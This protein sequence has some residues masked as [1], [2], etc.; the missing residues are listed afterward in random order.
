MVIEEL[1]VKRENGKRKIIPTGKTFE[2]FTEVCGYCLDYGRK[3]NPNR[4]ML[5]MKFKILDSNEVFCVGIGWD[6]DKEV[7]VDMCFPELNE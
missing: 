1:M 6:S 3:L 4:D 2:S 5:L 7:Y